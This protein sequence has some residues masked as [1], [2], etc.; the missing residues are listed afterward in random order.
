MALSQAEMKQNILELHAELERSQINIPPTLRAV[1]NQCAH[2]PRE[3]QLTNRRYDTAMLEG[4]EAQAAELGQPEER[5][6]GGMSW[7]GLFLGAL[8]GAVVLGGA[9][10]AHDEEQRRRRRE[11]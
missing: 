6:A 11:R 1:R 9:A 3:F 10:I 4:S 7:G 8:A 2:P 5:Q